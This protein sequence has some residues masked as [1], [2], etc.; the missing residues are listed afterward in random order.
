M[1][2][3]AALANH[4]WSS[5]PCITCQAGPARCD[6][7]GPVVVPLPVLVCIVGTHG[8]VL[9]ALSRAV[10]LGSMC[11]AA[12]TQGLGARMITQDRKVL[13]NKALN[14]LLAM[15]VALQRELM[16][17]LLCLLARDVA[18]AKRAGMH[19]VE[20]VVVPSCSSVQLSSVQ[21]HSVPLSS[22]QQQE[23]ESGSGIQQHLGGLV[24]PG[25]CADVKLIK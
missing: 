11:S 20:G 21:E 1:C 25:R 10:H 14:R 19:Q 22:L 16:D 12:L 17:T 7:I 24:G 6:A 5:C 9:H 23:E 18:A 8:G 4:V 15:P 13:V 2:I 3:S